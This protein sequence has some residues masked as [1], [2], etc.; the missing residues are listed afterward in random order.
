MSE[1]TRDSLLDEFA[2]SVRLEVGDRLKRHEDEI[3]IYKGG[4]WYSASVRE[5]R[6]NPP[7]QRY[8]LCAVLVGD[9][10]LAIRKNRPAWQAGRLNLPGGKVEP[11]ENPFQAAR[12]ELE[13]ETGLC[14]LR[15]PIHVGTLKGP[16]YLVDLMGCDTRNTQFNQ[17]TDEEVFWI[18]IKKLL[19]DP[20]TINELRV[21]IPLL[22]GGTYGWTLHG[23]LDDDT[24]WRLELPCVPQ[25]T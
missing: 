17:T 11:G 23:S 25:P 19:A 1:D 18:E 22:L 16:G 21:T 10:I 7:V 13:E 2:R 6:P 5:I 12:R 20:Q 3:D 9:K 15:E 4:S 14:V 8:V 24:N